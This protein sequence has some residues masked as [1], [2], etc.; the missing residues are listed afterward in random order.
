MTL[1]S[2]F[3]DR[4]DPVD[5]FVAELSA[6]AAANRANEAA[7]S[8]STVRAL[9]EQA[10][11][12]STWSGLAVDLAEAG[13]AVVAAVAGHRWSGRLVGAGR[14]FVV[15]ARAA[16]GPVLIA[17]DALISLT[18]TEPGPRSAGG[19]RPAGRR[20]PA[21]DLGLDGALEA[22]VAEGSPV[23]VWAG[24]ERYEGRLVSLGRDLLTLAPRPGAGDGVH[25]RL[26]ALDAVELR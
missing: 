11:A 12:D 14:D 19:S 22:L 25:V 23:V 8:R 13:V 9:V 7:R 17:D 1:P 20:R 24:G 10:A 21:L 15:L 4:D 5:A 2:P 26:G 18:R 16:A 6:W 3:V